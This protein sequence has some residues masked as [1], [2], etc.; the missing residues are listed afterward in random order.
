MV[1]TCRDDRLHQR[2]PGHKIKRRSNVDFK[3]KQVAWRENLESGEEN[4][5]K[6]IDIDQPETFKW[7]STNTKISINAN[8]IYLNLLQ[9]QI[10]TQL[11]SAHQAVCKSRYKGKRSM[12]RSVGM[13]QNQGVCQGQAGVGSSGRGRKDEHCDPAESARAGG[14]AEGNR[15]RR[16]VGEMWPL[17]LPSYVM[18]TW[19]KPSERPQCVNNYEYRVTGGVLTCEPDPIPNHGVLSNDH[20]VHHHHHQA[21]HHHQSPGLPK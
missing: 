11:N 5:F 19:S 7:S 13:H 18:I 10:E 20:Q 17:L 9:I 8:A 4:E 21:P 3:N 6:T 14:V 1:S 15:E 2:V 16:Q 12:K